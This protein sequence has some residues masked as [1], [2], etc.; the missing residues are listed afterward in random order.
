[1][2]KISILPLAEKVSADNMYGSNYSR[3]KFRIVIPA[4]VYLILFA[5]TVAMFFIHP[6]LVIFMMGIVCILAGIDSGG[7]MRKNGRIVENNAWNRLPI[8]IIG[9]SILLIAFAVE[10]S[11]IRHNKGSGNDDTNI[12]GRVVMFIIVAIAA[13]IIGR[14]IYLIVTAFAISS[15]KKAC[16]CPV[17]VEPDG[18]TAYY[19]GT[20]QT[21]DNV[22]SGKSIYKYYYEGENYRFIDH[23]NEWSYSFDPNGSD[24]YIDPGEPERY[25]SKQLFI[26]NAKK[27]KGFFKTILIIALVTLPFWG[28]YLFIRIYSYK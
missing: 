1:M 14:L 19:S 10:F 23:D 4:V 20:A 8:L 25:Y 11:G 6:V 5:V 7:T 26:G 3:E 15:R 16:T 24:I 17:H 9:I 28:S 2:K 18:N 27:L 21:G 22:F 13:I 12:V